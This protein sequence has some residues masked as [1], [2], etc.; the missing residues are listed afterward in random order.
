MPLVLSSVQDEDFFACVDLMFD[1]LGTR[2]PIVPACYPHAF[3]SDGTRDPD[4][5]EYHAN[6]MLQHKNQ[7][8]SEHWLK[9]TDTDINKIIGMILYII[10]DDPR[11]KPQEWVID[12]PE[13]YWPTAEDKEWAQALFKSRVRDRRAFIRETRKPVMCRCNLCSS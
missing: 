4:G 7:D 11:K 3:K 10:V 6:L 2:E 9:V 5:R 13:G 8:P 1:A 12:G